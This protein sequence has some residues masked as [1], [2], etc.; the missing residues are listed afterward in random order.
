[1]IWQLMI[2]VEQSVEVM[3]ITPSEEVCEGIRFA[4]MMVY[5]APADQIAC[6]PGEMPAI[7]LPN[8]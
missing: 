6:A 1:M 7:G 8:V 3:A 2:I 5:G 4:M